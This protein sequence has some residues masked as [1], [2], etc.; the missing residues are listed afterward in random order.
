MK[1]ATH[2]HLLP[3]LRKW[4]CSSATSYTFMIYA[5]RIWFCLH[6]YYIL[7]RW[8]MYLDFPS[9]HFLLKHSAFRNVVL[10]SLSD[11]IQEIWFI[12]H[13]Q[14]RKFNHFYSVHF[15]ERFVSNKIILFQILITQ[16]ILLEYWFILGNQVVSIL[17]INYRPDC[18]VGDVI[19]T[20]NLMLW[21]FN[22]YSILI[23]FEY[24]I[25]QLYL[26]LI[27]CMK[28]LSWNM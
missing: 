6:V 5:G 27:C 17:I 23:P 8:N 21:S 16:F 28:W 25:K 4:I 3:R 14:Q 11:K 26:Q 9:L 13:T 2:P 7:L 1:L 12:Q 22:N 18:F 19:Y 24:I 15:T 20:P 10:L